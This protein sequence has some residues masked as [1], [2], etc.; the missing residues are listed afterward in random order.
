MI[1]ADQDDNYYNDALDWFDKLWRKYESEPPTNTQVT[2]ALKR[3]QQQI[4]SITSYMKSE[5]IPRRTNGE[6]AVND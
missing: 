3:A 4:A 1:L 5:G 6:A 2:R